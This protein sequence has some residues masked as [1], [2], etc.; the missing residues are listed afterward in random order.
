M[1][2][3]PGYVIGLGSIE[4]TTAAAMGAKKIRTGHLACREGVWIVSLFLNGNRKPLQSVFGNNLLRRKRRIPQSNNCA[5]FPCPR[6][7]D[8]GNGKE[9]VRGSRQTAPESESVRRA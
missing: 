4:V 7:P 6:V 3:W 9:K 5:S 1:F 8:C 2:F